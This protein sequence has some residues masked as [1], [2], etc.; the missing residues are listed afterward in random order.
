[1]SKGNNNDNQVREGGNNGQINESHGGGGN[2]GTPDFGP[3]KRRD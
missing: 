2:H 3:E 1:M